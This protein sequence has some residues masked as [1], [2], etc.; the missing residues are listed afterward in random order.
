M[1]NKIQFAHGVM[2]FANNFSKR[3]Y[4]PEPESKVKSSKP[5]AIT[6]QPATAG[7][8]NLSN[9]APV[10]SP[11]QL[12]AAQKVEQE[13]QARAQAEAAEKVKVVAPVEPVKAAV[14]PAAK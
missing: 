7:A 6:T 5:A 8:A 14:Q 4:P 2:V 9:P 13:E 10:L 3:E 11:A 1:T 12:A